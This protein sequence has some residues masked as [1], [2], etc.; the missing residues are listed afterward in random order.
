[1]DYYRR[2]GVARNAGREEIRSA[3]RNL[4]V[5]Y[6][7]DK[8]GSDEAFMLLKEAEQTLVNSERRATYDAQLALKEEADR[9]MR[10]Y[11]VVHS[12]WGARPADETASLSE[13]QRRREAWSKAIFAIVT[14][15]KQY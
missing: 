9:R 1:M 5:R 4:A 3:F 6:H 7:S 15:F 8:G 12:P 13:E 14:L 2:L 11:L 10:E